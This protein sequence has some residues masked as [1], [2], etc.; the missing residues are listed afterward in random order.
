MGRLCSPT[1]EGRKTDARVY[2]IGG[3]LF[4]PRRA[5]APTL[6]LIVVVDGVHDNVH[7][8]MK[9]S[10]TMSAAGRGRQNAQERRSRTS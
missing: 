1:K 10:W 2:A 5:W 7:H 8:P 9:L 3:L 6:T 4:E